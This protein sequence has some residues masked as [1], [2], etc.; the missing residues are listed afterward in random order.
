MILAYCNIT[1]C[2][3]RKLLK[4]IKTECDFILTDIVEFNAV[5]CHILK[6]NP[7][8]SGVLMRVFGV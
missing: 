2:C 8:S 7:D 4:H 5:L 3:E 6:W 1:V